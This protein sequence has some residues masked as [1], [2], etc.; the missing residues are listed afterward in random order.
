MVMTV[1]N[2]NYDHKCVYS[3]NNGNNNITKNNSDNT[4][5][6]EEVF[7]LPGVTDVD[8][9]RVPSKVDHADNKELPAESVYN[10]ELSPT[11]A[12]TFPSVEIHT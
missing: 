12:L 3:K 2:E 5:I 6:V 1:V 8:H 11:I 7:L 9:K 10:V 4:N